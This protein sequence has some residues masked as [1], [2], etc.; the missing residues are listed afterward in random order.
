MLDYVVFNFRELVNEIN[1]LFSM[2]ISLNGLQYTCTIEDAVPAEI[3]SDPNRIRQVMLNLIGNA[4]KHNCENGRLELAITKSMHSG[5]ETLLVEVTDTGEGVPPDKL[6]TLFTLE[7][8]VSEANAGE[9]ASVSLPIAFQICK[10]LGGELEVRTALGTGSTFSF[11]IEIGKDGTMTERSSSL[12]MSN[13]SEEYDV[14]DDGDDLP[15]VQRPIVSRAKN[16]LAKGTVRPNSFAEPEEEKFRREDPAPLQIAL[17][18]SASGSTRRFVRATKRFSQKSLM[19]PRNGSE[20]DRRKDGS[21]SSIKPV[22]C[23]TVTDEVSQNPLAR[24]WLSH[25]DVGIRIKQRLCEWAKAGESLACQLK[26]RDFLRKTMVRDPKAI[27]KNAIISRNSLFIPTESPKG[28]HVRKI[29]RVR[30]DLLRFQQVTDS[31]SVAPS[32][33]RDSPAA[34]VQTEFQADCILRELHRV[35]IAP[36]SATKTGK[37]QQRKGR[38]GQPMRTKV[39][40]RHA[41]IHFAQVPVACL[42][43]NAEKRTAAETK[44]QHQPAPQSQPQTN[45]EVLAEITRGIARRLKLKKC[46]KPDCAD[47][48]VVD[49]NEFNR[50]IMAQL[51]KKYGFVYKMV[52]SRRDL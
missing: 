13:M 15:V 47:I 27:R 19:A 51:L 9:R 36:S 12:A 49:D 44:Q 24:R 48:L 39:L 28:F 5:A 50:F 4:I 14:R 11:H 38:G 52:Q 43:T 35:L 21:P 32:S 26:T 17:L 46:A 29:N 34:R 30:G 23:E 16:A 18:N 7:E 31:P 25:N 40:L 1:N 37:Q 22:P 42:D 10:L 45:E 8:I 20:S 41:C 3:R 33:Y 2:Q 6:K